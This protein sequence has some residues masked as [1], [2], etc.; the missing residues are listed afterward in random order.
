MTITE[1]FAVNAAQCPPFEAGQ[2]S[3]F[4]AQIEMM[5]HLLQVLYTFEQKAAQTNR[6]DVAQAFSSAR[7]L[8]TKL[9]DVTVEVAHGLATKHGA[10]V[11]ISK[12]EGQA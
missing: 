5:G 9:H 10:I 2:L 4:G 3:A 8:L 7:E 1:P 11:P 12:Q 6:P